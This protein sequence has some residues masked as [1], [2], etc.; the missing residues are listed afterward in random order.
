[1][2]ELEPVPSETSLPLANPAISSPSLKHRS[3]GSC[4][5][6]LVFVVMLAWIITPAILRHWI[7]LGTTISPGP[8]NTRSAV[9]GLMIATIVIAI[10][11]L[12][13][14]IF[15]P[16]LRYR[17]IYQSWILAL[18]LGILLSS[19]YLAHPTAAQT[20]AVIQ[21][22][23]LLLFCLLVL[24]LS[25]WLERRRAAAD[26]LDSLEVPRTDDPDQAGTTGHTAIPMSAL[27][28][29][30]RW[31]LALFVGLLAA[32]PW[33][34]WGALGSFLDTLLA[35]GLG[36]S[37]G[38]ASAL[39]LGRLVFPS[40]RYTSAAA[41]APGASFW[42]DYALTA[43]SSS[44]LLLLMASS[45]AFSYGGYQILLMLILPALGWLL[46]AVEELEL[47]SAESND[48]LSPVSVSRLWPLAALIGLVAAAPLAF[49]DGDELMLVVTASAG[50]LLVWAFK[51]A[52]AGLFI[53][54]CL[55]LAALLFMLIWRSGATTSAKQNEHE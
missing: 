15:W 32:L 9:I 23:L 27:P 8:T 10:P 21:I 18:G 19:A 29:A 5:D 25:A 46:A 7:T 28:Q 52:G 17:R 47:P 39:L 35:I 26:R 50:E 36:L 31:S 4:V 48:S 1:M 16:S 22:V 53:L 30:A 34:A 13:L 54:L 49:I 6:I 2:L 20:Q 11:L 41:S 44:A 55:D 40:I 51:A 45:T 24:W 43:L 12:P 38:L 37:L 3:G 33:V 14:A 42:G